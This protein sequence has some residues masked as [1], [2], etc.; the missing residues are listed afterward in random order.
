LEYFLT[1]VK[2]TTPHVSAI[3]YRTVRIQM[4]EVSK[5]RVTLI[6]IGGEAGINQA[7]GRIM[8]QNMK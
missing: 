3:I 8:F 1:R 5:D 4:A 2:L 6:P 7:F